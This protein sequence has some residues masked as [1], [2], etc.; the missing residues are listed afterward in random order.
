MPENNKKSHLAAVLESVSRLLQEDDMQGIVIGGIAASIIGK[1]RYTNDVDLVILDIDER[2]PA[3]IEKLKKYDIEPR[4]S[5]AQ[6]FAKKSRML[7]MRHLPSKINIDIS[8]GLLP[9]EREAVLRQ[10]TTNFQ[11]IKIPLPAPEDLIVFKSISPR[12]LDEEDIKGI[13]SRNPQI[14]KKR[15][16]STVREFSEI[17]EKPEIYDKIRAL[18]T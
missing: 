4:I 5:D 8:M 15:V 6:E 14:D 16:L 1:P 9:F 12:A 2:I 13:L 18:L 17:M 11:G 10:Q 7:L 3:V